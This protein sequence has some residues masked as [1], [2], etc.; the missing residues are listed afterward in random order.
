M[1]KNDGEEESEWVWRKHFLKLDF[2]KQYHSHFSKHWSEMEKAP[3]EDDIKQDWR[4]IRAKYHKLI[5]NLVV[6]FKKQY[7][8]QD[9][10]TDEERDKR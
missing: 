5:E 1:H 6:D 2:W 7:H 4:H 8:I 9:E 10:E 3:W